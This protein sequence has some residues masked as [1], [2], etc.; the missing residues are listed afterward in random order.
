MGLAKIIMRIFASAACMAFSL[1]PV[2]CPLRAQDVVY[3][4]ESACESLEKGEIDEAQRILQE[5]LEINPDNLNA[6]LYLGIAL[7][8]KND[9][10]NAATK[11][12]KVERE[13]DRIIGASRPFGDTV[14]FTELG[15]E[16]RAEQLFSKKRRGLLYF[17]R[18]LSMKE[19]GDWKN[20][21]KKFK[22]ALKQK[23]DE[24]AVRLHLFDISVKKQDLKAAA[25]QLSNLKKMREE[26]EISV[27]LGGYLMYRE[28]DSAGALASFQKLAP[29][30]S[31]AKNNMA[32]IYYNGGDYS[33]ARQ[34]WEEILSEN[35]EAKEAQINI[36]RASFHLGETEKAQEFFS[37][38]GIKTPPE[39]ASPQKLSLTYDHLLKELI[40]DLMCKVK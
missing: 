5:A 34:I 27:F 28:G 29:T 30:N 38:A 26:S 7:Y 2:S 6:L 14:E 36:G 11:F 24:K 40:F 22:E 15:M 1:Q 37:Q 10:E 3:W 13:V 33:K 12:A 19:A 8:Y 39:K 25:E 32:L 9:L 35:P 4:E 23:Y 21:E 17:C 18:G 16:R 20:A 31:A